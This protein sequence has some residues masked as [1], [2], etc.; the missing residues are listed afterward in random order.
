MR[1]KRTPGQLVLP[2]GMVL[3]TLAVVGCGV[4]GVAAVAWRGDAVQ[5][6]SWQKISGKPF[7]YSGV[8]DGINDRENS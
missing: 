1:A 7:A 4:G 3:A 5:V 6:P 8:P 2:L